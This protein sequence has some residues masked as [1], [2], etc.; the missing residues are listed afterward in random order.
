MQLARRRHDAVERLDPAARK[1]E[2]SRHEFMAVMAAAQQ[3]LRRGCLGTIDQ[4][5]RRGVARL[6][7]GR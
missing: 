4:H 2:F 7:I 1:Y 6:A 3:N 5:D